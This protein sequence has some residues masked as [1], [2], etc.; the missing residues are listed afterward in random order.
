MTPCLHFRFALLFAVLLAPVAAYPQARAPMET[1]RTPMAPP[2]KTGTLREVQTKGKIAT[3][4]IDLDEGGDPLEIK[5]TPLINFSVATS[6]DAG[7]VAPGQIMTS[8]GVLTQEKVFLTDITIHLLPKAKRPATGKIQ[9][10]PDLMEGQSVNT[11]QVS[12][13]ILSV[14]PAE[15]YPDYTQVGVKIAGRA[16]LV[17]LEKD[18]KVWVNS[19]DSAHAP[20]GAKVTVTGK[21]LAGGRFNPTAVKVQREEPLNSAE[22][23]GSGDK[24]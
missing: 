8:T 15:G 24:P 3:L 2:T 20:A 7:F 19:T 10:A 21:L 18:Y 22:V 23:L 11:Y 12:G 9:K 5:L 17:W 14:G 13:P 1:P 6:G 4:V 16:P